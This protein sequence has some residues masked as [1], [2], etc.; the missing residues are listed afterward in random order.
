MSA[1]LVTATR[2][3]HRTAAL[4]AFAVFG[5]LTCGL[6]TAAGGAASAQPTSQTKEKDGDTKD[7]KDKTADAMG[8]RDV[9]Q[10]L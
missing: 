3:K 2:R 10:L 4:A 8:K 6:F 5:G 9:R 7:A 1:R